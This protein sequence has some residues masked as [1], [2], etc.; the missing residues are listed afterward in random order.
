[1]NNELSELKERIIAARELI[2]QYPEIS[3]I[4]VVDDDSNQATVLNTKIGMAIINGQN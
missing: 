3:E 1:M 2:K 4:I